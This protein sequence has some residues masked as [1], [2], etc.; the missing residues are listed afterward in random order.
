MPP[1]RRK[2]KP[3]D[4][5]A[6]MSSYTKHASPFCHLPALHQPDG[7]A[8]KPPVR[9]QSFL[10]KKKAAGDKSP[11][12]FNF[13]SFLNQISQLSQQLH[14]FFPML[15][16]LRTT[17]HLTSHIKG[18]HQFTLMIHSHFTSSPRFSKCFTTAFKIYWY[19]FSVTTSSSWGG[20]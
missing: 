8:T 19:S 2:K 3:S 13:I 7:I 18:R 12:A 20:R 4:K 6:D 11:T 14:R 16:F 9:V 1:A 10:K 15:I 5:I 17:P